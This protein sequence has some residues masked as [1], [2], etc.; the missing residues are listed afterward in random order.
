[1]T[2][3]EL[4]SLIVGILLGNILC[5]FVQYLGAVVFC[6][7]RRRKSRRDA[8]MAVVIKRLQKECDEEDRLAA[9]KRGRVDLLPADFRLD[10]TDERELC[11]LFRSAVID[12]RSKDRR[13]FFPGE[14]TGG[15]N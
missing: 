8:A 2:R 15:I 1:M 13:R 10:V 3:T 7:Y 4:L 12:L 6:W 9:A 14:P 11:L 5:L